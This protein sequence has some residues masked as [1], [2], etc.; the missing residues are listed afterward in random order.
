M[1]KG[2]LPR[3]VRAKGFPL[4]TCKPAPFSGITFDADVL[5][6]GAQEGECPK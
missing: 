6:M 4:A 2:W 5:T 1:G 3:G